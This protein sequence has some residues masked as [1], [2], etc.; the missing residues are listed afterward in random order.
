MPGLLCVWKSCGQRHEFLFRQ[1][2]EPAEIGGGAFRVVIAGLTRAIPVVG[3]LLGAIPLVLVCLIMKRDVNTTILLLVMFT[4]MHFLE[5][6]VLLPKIVGHEVNLHPV[7]VILALLL[8][9]EFF[10][11]LGVFLAVPIAAVLKILLDEWQ[12]SVSN[13]GRLEEPEAVA[14]PG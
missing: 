1:T 12:E 6:K 2:G 14:G 11:V 9:M 4:A 7:S 10:G 13:R 8:G 5:S 3:P